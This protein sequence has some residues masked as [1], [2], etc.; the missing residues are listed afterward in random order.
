MKTL[1]L[2]ALAEGVEALRALTPA[3]LSALNHGTVRSPIPGQE[4][5]IVLGKCRQWAAQAGRDQNLG[6]QCESGRHPS[7]RGGGYREHPRE[8]DRRSTV[9][10]YRIQK[11]RQLVYESLDL[12]ESQGWLPQTLGDARGGARNASCEVLIRNVREMNPEEF[13]NSE[14][15]WRIVIDWP[16]DEPPFT[17]RST[18]WLRCG[19]SR[20]QGEPAD[21]HRVAAL[22]LY[23]VRRSATS[24]GWCCSIRC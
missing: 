6:R 12:D 13:R 5:Q 11:V 22:V 17:R 10:G 14:G 24:D 8:R 3:R 21:T 19:T 20:R 15:L 2:S 4:S 23:G 16:F 18:I 7:D 1:L 9:D